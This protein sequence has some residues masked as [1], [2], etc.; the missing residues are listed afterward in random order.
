MS[1][2]LRLADRPSIGVQLGRVNG[3]G[4]TTWDR[5]GAAVGLADPTAKIVIIRFIYELSGNWEEWETN[6]P[7]MLAPLA[8]GEEEE[9]GCG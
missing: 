4:G 6:T 2:Q 1:G 7:A 5:A 9:V 3:I 8:G